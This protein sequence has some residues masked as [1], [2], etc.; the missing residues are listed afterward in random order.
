M[1]PYLD[2]DKD[3][4]NVTSTIY[5]LVAVTNHCGTMLDGHY[6]AYCKHVDDEP[7]GNDADDDHP[8]SPSESLFCNQERGGLA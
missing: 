3:C 1:S 5:D 4:C 7:S 8:V 2:T 6:Y